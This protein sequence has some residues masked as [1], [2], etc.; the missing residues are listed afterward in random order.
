[1][2]RALEELGIDPEQRERENSLLRRR[3]LKVVPIWPPTAILVEDEAH[4]RG[5]TA[6]DKAVREVS[7][8]AC[9]QS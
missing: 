4:L 6:A 3:R 7:R 9:A 8:T 2:D 1:M 5:S